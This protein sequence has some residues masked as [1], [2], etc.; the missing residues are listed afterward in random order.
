MGRNEEGERGE[1]GEGE[2]GERGREW[3]EG[4][5]RLFHVFLRSWQIS[6]GVNYTCMLNT[7]DCPMG[8]GLC[9]MKNEKREIEKWMTNY[10]HTSPLGE[11]KCTQC[12]FTQ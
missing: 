6:A 4:R 2:G 1:E 11:R 7:A 5:E 9:I 3:R 12:N 8:G 10:T